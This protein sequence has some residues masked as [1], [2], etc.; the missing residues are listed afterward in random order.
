MSHQVSTALILAGGRSRRM[1]Q[2]K[3]FLLHEGI[4]LIWRVAEAARELT[5]D[6]RI[7]LS[8][9]DPRVSAQNSLTI[10]D[11]F[12]GEGPLSALAG[13]LDQAR[14]PYALVLAADYPMLDGKFL[15]KFKE[16][17]DSAAGVP[18]VVVPVADG[19][20]QVT[21]AFYRVALAGELASARESGERSLRRWTERRLS[22]VERIDQDKWRDWSNPDALFNVNTPGEYE[23]L[24][25]SGFR[26]QGSGRD[27]AR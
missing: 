15:R 5:G 1:G 4:P 3:R 19:I 13:A 17:L 11:R 6:V 14:G 24:E 8:D 23:Q 21:C 20:M 10:V 25:G 7:L 2:D 12:P 22:G 9:D 18:D 16:A 26:G 27:P